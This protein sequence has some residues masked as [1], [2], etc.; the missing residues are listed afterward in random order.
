MCH[1]KLMVEAAWSATLTV[2]RKS[3]FTG[4]ES[5]WISYVCHGHGN[6]ECGMNAVKEAVGLKRDGLLQGY[7]GLE[8]ITTWMR[9]KR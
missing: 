8:V 1:L 3:G 9:E 7:M 5:R 4:I 6:G 2:S